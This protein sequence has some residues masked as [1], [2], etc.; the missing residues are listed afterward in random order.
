MG[1]LDTYLP[2]NIRLDRLFEQLNAGVVV[3]D[4]NTSIL[5]ANKEASRLLN[6]SVEQINGKVAIDPIWH[7]VREDQSR[8]PTEEYPVNKI[9]TG[10]QQIEKEIYGIQNLETGLIN[11]VEVSGYPEYDDSDQLTQVVVTFVDITSKKKSSDELRILFEITHGVIHTTSLPQ[12]LKL[13]HQ[14]LQKLM[15]AE[16]CFFALH[17]EQKDIFEFPYFVDQHD[18]EFQPVQVVKSCTAYTF[19]TGEPILMT[20]TKFNELVMQKEIELV[21]SPSPSWMG[22]PLKSSSRTIGVL[23]L[24]HYTLENIYNQ[25]HLDFLNSLGSQVAN[26]IERKRAEYD[27][28]KANSLNKATLESTADGILVVDEAG[29]IT[30]YNSKFLELWH[31]PEQI[32]QNRDDKQLLRFVADRL[33]DPE[34]FLDKVNC[35]YQN[36]QTISTDLIA[37]KDGRT[38]ER[39][40]QAQL[41]NGQYMGRVW[42]FRDITRQVEMLRKLQANEVRLNELNATKDK[43]FSIIAH[44]L[45]SPFNAILGFSNLLTSQLKEKDYQG[46]EEYAEIIQ[47]STQKALDLLINLMDWSRAQS[48]QLNFNPR[49]LNV[50]ELIDEV[51]EIS[52]IAA[53][54]K[55]LT[56]TAEIDQTKFFLLDKDMIS[57][58]MRNLLS[59]AIK[60]TNPGGKIHL[61]ARQTG[62]EL[63]I[64]IRDSG[65][66]MRENELK[67]LFR[68]DENYSVPG[69]NNERGTG[70]G[71]I[72][73]K[74]F[75]DKHQG[76]IWAESTPGQGSQFFFSIPSNR[77][78]N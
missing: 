72:I 49:V 13:I 66:G 56:I 48:G 2:Q 25:H 57:S 28:E 38:F 37:F 64:S 36:I 74:E 26:V 12:L 7:F 41:C 65:V 46:V 24:Q 34:G 50:A 10:C 8:L 60:F 15:Y 77:F 55:L 47:F 22:I 31:I 35:L 39:Y 70:L 29:K 68:I 23:V 14:S 71:L 75:I 52:K 17:D 5:F 4:R 20:P 51:I 42:S 67:K 18:R 9:L 54:Q 32:V 3:H 76:R 62:T 44:D 63:L 27:L 21:G 78:N 58:V 40:S 59:N 45:K 6:L 53:T 1:T 19:R 73:C 33:T 11:W 43:F 30:S 16:N 61:T 69:T